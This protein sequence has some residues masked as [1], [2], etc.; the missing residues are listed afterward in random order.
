MVGK[1][2][3]KSVLLNEYNMLDILP[4]YF[5]LTTVNSMFHSL[6]TGEFI[7]RLKLYPNI[8]LSQLI[9]PFIITLDDYFFLFNFYPY[10]YI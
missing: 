4:D 2:G 1:V 6:L 3:N 8:K 7:E 10:E 5:Y 9:I